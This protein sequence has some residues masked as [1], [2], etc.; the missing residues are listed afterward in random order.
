V[1]AS[2]VI[3]PESTVV[4]T[5]VDRF[6]RRRADDAEGERFA[7]QGTNN[8]QTAQCLRVPILAKASGN[9]RHLTSGNP[10]PIIGAHRGTKSVKWWSRSQTKVQAN[11]GIP[12][13]WPY[14]GSAV[15]YVH[16]EGET[17]ALGG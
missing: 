12:L 13:N 3:Q 10:V 7:A 14:C 4:E 11:P 1:E 8:C 9:T 6:R 16:T 15:A 5:Q 17:A 2:G